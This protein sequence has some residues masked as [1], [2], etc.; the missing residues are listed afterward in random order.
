M[1]SKTRGKQHRIGMSVSV[2]LCF[3]T[4]SNFIID[5][6]L[7]KEKHIHPKLVLQSEIYFGLH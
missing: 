1:V 3:Y 5:A 2:N 6:D 7:F 4:K